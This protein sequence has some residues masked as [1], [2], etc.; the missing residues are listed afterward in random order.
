MHRFLPFIHI[1]LDRT[2]APVMLAQD[3]AGPS[4]RDASTTGLRHGAWCLAASQPPL[5]EI[6]SVWESMECLGRSGQLPTLGGGPPDCLAL[7]ESRVQLPLVYRTMVPKSWMDGTVAWTKILARRWRFTVDIGTGELKTSAMWPRIL[8]RISTARR[9]DTIA[10]GDNQGAVGTASRGRSGKP[11]QN[12]SMRSWAAYEAVSF[13]RTRSTW[14]PTWAQPADGGTR[15][16][17]R[18]RLLVGPVLWPR[19]AVV[20]QLGPALPQLREAL[21]AGGFAL[22][23]FPDLEFGRPCL[24]A[25]HAR[26]A[27]RLVESNTA[28]LL[29]VSVAFVRRSRAS[30]RWDF[31]TDPAFALLI[32]L[33][34]V[35]KRGRCRIIIR[36]ASSPSLITNHLFRSLLDSFSGKSAQCHLCQYGSVYRSACTLHGDASLVTALARVCLGGRSCTRTGLPHLKPTDIVDD[37]LTSLGNFSRAVAAHLGTLDRG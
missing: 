15:P 36:D 6:R 3:A 21:A 4:G 12:S 29:I 26:S 22:H 33:I 28:L 2:P 23:F 20:I 18:G 24:S 17:R 25:A 11:W 19:Q 7:A 13:F 27:S 16:D 35:A 37:R 5:A 9:F 34:M 30:V 31:A 32:K 8:A 10:L 14:T 1:E